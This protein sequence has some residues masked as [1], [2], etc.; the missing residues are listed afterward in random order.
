MSATQSRHS[1]TIVG[2]ALA[3]GGT[4]FISAAHGVFL[5]PTKGLRDWRVQMCE[6]DVVVFEDIA[7][8]VLAELGYELRY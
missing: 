7:G 4:A 1:G 6:S 8:D 2:S 5:P 3:R